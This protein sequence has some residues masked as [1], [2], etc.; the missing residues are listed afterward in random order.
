[1]KKTLSLLLA[2][3]LAIPVAHAGIFDFVKGLIKGNTIFLAPPENIDLAKYHALVINAGAGPESAQLADMAEEQLAGLKGAGLPYYSRVFR[4][5][6]VKTDAFD[7]AVISITAGPSQVSDS[8][9]SE[10][11][12]QCTNGKN[13]CDSN[14]SRQYTVGCS[15]RT[16]VTPLSISIRDNVTNAPLVPLS[17][18]QG[19]VSTKSQLCSDQSGALKD[20]AELVGE[21]YVSAIGKLVERIGPKQDKRPLDLISSDDSISGADAVKLKVAYESAGRSDMVTACRLYNELN[22]S[23][24]NNGVILFNK[25]YCRHSIGA[26]AQAQALYEQSAAAD[27]SPKDLLATYQAEVNDWLAKGVQAVI[28]TIPAQA[29]AAA[30][31]QPAVSVAPTTVAPQPATPKPAAPVAVATASSSGGDVS[32]RLSQIKAL[33]DDGIITKEEYNA[34]R[35]AILDAM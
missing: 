8:A 29:L 32:K 23:K 19:S 34:K 21:N 1:M 12:V 17:S 5:T 22:V 9:G 27:A 20:G 2:A 28:V 15:I 11:R 16:A 26:F 24:P 18:Q 35:K 33:F 4:N 30:Q 14:Q 31:A 25:G 7:I 13:V 10:V 6:A 3:H